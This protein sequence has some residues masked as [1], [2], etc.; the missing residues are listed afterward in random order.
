MTNR[1][2]HFL[3][4]TIFA[5]AFSCKAQTIINNE[6]FRNVN[7]P[8]DAYIKDINNNHDTVVGTWLWE[9]N[10]GSSFELVIEESEMYPDPLPSS[11][12]YWD[13]L[14]GKYRYVQNYDEKINVLNNTYSPYTAPFHMTIETPQK[15]ILT[16]G[17]LSTG[18]VFKGEFI[19]TSP[20]TATME[21]QMTEGL[22]IIEP[23]QPDLPFSLPTS[24][25]L[26][27]Q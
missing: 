26:T 15:Y 6:N 24:M 13:E 2:K 14:F 3:I 17:D 1:M 10:N 22:K 4:I 23:G 19:L 12:Q 20:T 5:T 18:K 11:N 25:T 27:K 21:L 7:L 16:I 9:N 8:N